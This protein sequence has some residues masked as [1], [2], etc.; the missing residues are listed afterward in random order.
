MLAS[1]LPV[2]G[3]SIV[4]AALSLAVAFAL[5]S[6]QVQGSSGAAEAADSRPRVAVEDE[7]N[8]SESGSI[9][10]ERPQVAVAATDG[11]VHVVWEEGQ[12]IVHRYRWQG[13][14]AWSTQHVVFRQGYDPAIA[15]DGSTVVVAFVRG[16]RD[17]AD[18]TEVLYKVWDS[19]T[20]TWPILAE[21]IQSGEENIA[22]DGQQPDVAFSVDG[23]VLWLAWIDTTWGEQQP[24]Y[25]R[26]RL[27][28]HAVDAGPIDTHSQGAQGTALDIGPED[29]VH[30]AWSKEN[31]TTKTS[32][33]MH[34]SRA[35]EAAWD[36]DDYPYHR[37]VKQARAPD[38][39]VSQNQWCLTWHENMQRENGGLPQPNNEV[40]LWCNSSNWNLSN[41][42]SHS[43]LPSLALDDD[44]GQMV[45]WR[46]NYS[47]REI[48]FRQGPPPPP[49]G[50]SRVEDGDVDTPSVH[51]SNGYAHSVWTS[52]G[53]RGSDVW[54][55]KWP[56]ALPT[57]TPSTT[58]TP[59]SSETPTATPTGTDGPPHHYIYLPY[60]TVA[61]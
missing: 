61:R 59:S 8:L 36:I 25:A 52:D 39:K 45:V 18:D 55:A 26:I 10:S 41:S 30:V 22:A 2:R 11:T 44:R 19:N 9:F 5:A 38:I 33:V 1:F 42:A 57:P 17:A 58:A 56:V 27:V 48:V 53:N 51:F 28:D 13:T 29:T 12:N 47:P 50:D 49:D 23:S 14:R 16:K 43:L 54:Y 46:E 35:A 60:S 37:E 3:N 4:A 6:L 21:Q 31:Y 34:A 15:T 40:V 24:Y 20:R 7:V 32:Y